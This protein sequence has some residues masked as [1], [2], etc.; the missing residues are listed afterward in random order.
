MAGTFALIPN[1]SN[2]PGAILPPSQLTVATRSETVS[3]K[4]STGGSSFSIVTVRFQPGFGWKATKNRPF[5]SSTTTLV[6]SAFGL[7]VG[8]RMAKREKLSAGDLVRVD[9][10]VSAR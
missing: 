7:S 6:V 8:T 4:T 5:G 10:D 1:S 9:G 3:P 2:S